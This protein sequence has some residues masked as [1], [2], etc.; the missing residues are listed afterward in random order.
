MWEGEEPNT[1]VDGKN[2]IDG[3]WVSSEIEITYIKLLN[4][5][6]SVGDH[7]KLYWSLARDPSLEHM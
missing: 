5:L 3:V 6:E 4:F 1:Y 2:P 7:R